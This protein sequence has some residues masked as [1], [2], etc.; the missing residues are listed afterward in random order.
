MNF[1]FNYGFQHFGQTPFFNISNIVQTLVGSCDLNVTTPC[2]ALSAHQAIVTTPTYLTDINETVTSY[3]YDTSGTGNT[4]TNVDND[5]AGF[6]Q[7]TISGNTSE[8]ADTASFT[9]K[10]P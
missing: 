1:G 5:S 4:V 8:A 10:L 2:T 9:M 3:S 6:T 7:S